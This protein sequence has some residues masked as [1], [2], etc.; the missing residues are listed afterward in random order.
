MATKKVGVYRSYYGPVPVDDA[1][2]PLPQSEWPR[3]RAHSWVVRWFGEDGNRYSKSFEARKEADRFAESK[4]AE[5]R[6]GKGEPPDDII[7]KTFIKLH[8]QVMKG[9]VAHETL[10]DQVR[11]LTMLMD[12]VGSDILLRK[13]TA[14]QAEEFVAE[15]LAAVKVATVNKDIRTLKRVFNLA[16]EPRG[17]LR[18][19]QNPFAR[20]KQRKQATKPVRYVRREEF[21][22]VTAA[23]PNLWWK[24]LLS[25]AY[26]TGAR[27][28]EIVNLTWADVD[29]ETGRIRIVSKEAD[30]DL[31]NWEPKDHEGRVLP[32]PPQVE[33]MLV[34]LQVEAVSGCPYVFVEPFRW[35][36]I[37]RARAEGRWDEDGQLMNNLIRRL[38]TLRRRA[39]VAKFTYHDLRRTCI[40]NWA[41]HLPIHVVRQL[42]GHSD[43]RTTQKYYLSVQDD[44]LGRARQVQAQI[45]GADL[46]DQEMTNSAR[47]GHLAGQK[48]KGPEA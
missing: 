5:V 40:T 22:A 7:L 34:D 4:Q 25:V 17:Y 16:I 8:R 38:N 1:G 47:K 30:A 18:P 43:I 3:K 46:T 32:I 42:A 39:K 24:G 31:S 29:F 21:Q 48:L 13:I 10:N 9:Q 35:E 45:L 12:H 6:E 28:E 20:I 36:Y 11:A 44:D 19:G 14:R 23:A 2:Q 33:E 27:I 37:Q 15:R 41:R 26:T